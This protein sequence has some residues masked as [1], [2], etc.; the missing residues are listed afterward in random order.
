L[1]V[2]NSPAGGGDW[3]M[4]FREQYEQEKKLTEEAGAKEEQPI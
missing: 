2:F 1:L 4:R 3:R